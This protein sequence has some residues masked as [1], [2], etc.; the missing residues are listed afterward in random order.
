MM[1]SS[2]LLVIIITGISG[3]DWLMRESVSRPVSP[4]MFSSRRMSENGSLSS[5]SSASGPLLAVATS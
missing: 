2:S 5:M 4:G 1:F 3:C